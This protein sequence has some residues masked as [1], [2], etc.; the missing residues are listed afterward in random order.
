MFHD[1][2][3]CNTHVIH[4]GHCPQTCHDME[5][6]NYHMSNVGHIN[7]YHGRPMPIPGESPMEAANRLNWNVKS[8]NKKFEQ[9]VCQMN[10]VITEAKKRIKDADAYYDYSVEKKELWS[11]ESNTA[12]WLIRIPR[13]DNTGCPIEMK[14]HLAYGD[15]SNARIVEDIRGASKF[16]LADT[17][18]SAAIGNPDI[19]A[20]ILSHG[21]TGHTFYNFAPLTSY[22][23]GSGYTVGFQKNGRMKWYNNAVEQIVLQRDCIENSIGCAAIAVINHA[24]T[25]SE[26]WGSETDSVYDTKARVM[27]GQDYVTNDTY[28]LVCG[29][30]GA[31]QKG[32][33]FYE[34]CE[35]MAKYCDVAVTMV[36]AVPNDDYGVTATDKG[37][38]L[39]TPSGIEAPSNFAFWYISR[40]PQYLNGNVFEIATL[41][42]MVGQLTWF[43][44]YHEPTIVEIMAKLDALE[45]TLMQ[46]LADA[47]ARIDQKVTDAINEINLLIANFRQEIAD[48]LADM[49]GVIQKLL[50][51]G[52]FNRLFDWGNVATGAIVAENA[53]SSTVAGT[54]NFGGG[55]SLQPPAQIDPG[56]IT[57][58]YAD[59]DYNE[60]KAIEIFVTMPFTVGND[61]SIYRGGS[62]PYEMSISIPTTGVFTQD[63]KDFITANYLNLRRVSSDFG[64]VLHSRDIRVPLSTTRL[65]ARS[66]AYHYNTN[67]IAILCTAPTINIPSTTPV[68]RGYIATEEDSYIQQNGWFTASITIEAR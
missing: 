38:P 43:G 6:K 63:I 40:A 68:D 64:L 57:V 20:P 35:I 41:I 8:M 21:F 31:N 33:P 29:E 60:I 18:F 65:E 53:N 66:F 56:T 62:T 7:H 58:T 1:K 3:E 61:F 26:Y 51:A 16:E 54:I 39:I 47:E 11:E 59:P 12:Y 10:G 36:A 30:N 32:M 46:M 67:T 25:T 52:A 50:D 17:M 9:A 44:E 55:V 49:D 4:G 48:K 42:Q 27:L 19:N 15:A 37:F 34:A 23:D 28:V 2:E 5:C 24:P 14:L 22:N 45:A 13:V